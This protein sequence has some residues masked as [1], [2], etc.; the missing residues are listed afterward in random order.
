MSDRMYSFKSDSDYEFYT[1]WYKDDNF[2]FMVEPI[3][4]VVFLHLAIFK[5][6]KT[7]VKKMH[8]I[9]LEIEQEMGK[10]GYKKL[11]MY[12]PEQPASWDKLITKFAKY[13][14]MY[15]IANG[16]HIYGKDLIC[17]HSLM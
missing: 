8:E 9:L 3:N 14:I 11:L 7:T 12:N 16:H 6:S 15:N 4:E 17:Q 13:P 1:S 10:L 2:E 5:W